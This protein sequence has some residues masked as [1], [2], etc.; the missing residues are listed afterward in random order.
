MPEWYGNGIWPRDD[1]STDPGAGVPG[2]DLHADLLARLERRVG[3]GDVDEL[4]AFPPRRA[5]ATE[6]VLLVA[7]VFDADGDRRRIVTARAVRR[8]ERGSVVAE[9]LVRELAEQGVAPADRVGRLLEGVLRRLDDPLTSEPPRTYRIGGDP[10][11]WR[12]AVG[13]LTG[14]PEED[15]PVAGAGP[16]E[17]GGTADDQPQ[18]SGPAVAEPA[19]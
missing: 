17:G 15:G 19:R 3:H 11:R 7:S 14:A 16:P 18:S 5:G 13:E 2:G 10:A 1:V 9:D 4:W 6:S 12:R 8:R